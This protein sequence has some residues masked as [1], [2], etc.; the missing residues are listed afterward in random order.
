MANEFLSGSSL[1]DHVRSLLQEP[2]IRAAVAFWGGGSENWVTSSGARIIC[3]LAMGGTNP[4]AIRKLRDRCEVLQSDT[5][6]AKVYVG[7][8]EAIV[9]SAN[10]SANGLGL[11]GV[12]QSGWIE[13]GTTTSDVGQVGDWFEKVWNDARVISDKDLADAEIAWAARRSARPPVATFASFDVEAEVLPLVGWQVA[14]LPFTLND[15]ALDDEMFA[16]TPDLRDRANRGIEINEREVTETMR[17]RWVLYFRRSDRGRMDR[18]IR[19]WFEMA[20]SIRIPKA[21]EYDHLPGK[22]DLLLAPDGAARQPFDP[23]E[24]RFVAAFQAA[25]GEEEFEDLLDEDEGVEAWFADRAK[26]TRAFWKRVRSIYIA[27]SQR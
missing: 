16:K 11:E 23:S 3:N 6:H 17:D 27:Q 8:K 21:F 25:I 15:D 9:T 2:G 10:A 7:S 20:G 19:P 18:R 26:V 4:K 5:L 12:E 22:R 1:S 14:L 24:V 13:A